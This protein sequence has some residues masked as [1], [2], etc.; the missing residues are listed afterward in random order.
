MYL[1]T[2]KQAYNPLKNGNRLINLKL[3]MSLEQVLNIKVNTI[4]KL[5]FRLPRWEILRYCLCFNQKDEFVHWTRQVRHVSQSFSFVV[6]LRCRH[7][8]LHGSNQIVFWSE[9]FYDTRQ[10]PIIACHIL[11]A[12]QHHVVDFDVAS[13]TC[14]LPALVDRIQVFLTPSCLE[15][16]RQIFNTT[17][18][19]I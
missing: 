16:V 2:Q 1:C 10:T 8:K 4:N 9:A 13:L 12:D 11:V 15:N 7:L 14:P 17:Q 3:Y 6:Q 19:L 5:I 18:A